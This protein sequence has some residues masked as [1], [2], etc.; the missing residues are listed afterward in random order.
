MICHEVLT[1]LSFLF[2]ACIFVMMLSS[3]SRGG[4]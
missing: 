3:M 1:A 4:R 2:L